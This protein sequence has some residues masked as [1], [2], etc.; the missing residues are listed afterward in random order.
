VTLAGAFVTARLNIWAQGFPKVQWIVMTALGIIYAGLIIWVLPS[1]ERRKVVPDIARWV[2]A[3]TGA[4]DR[5]ASY[6]LNRWSAAF[7][8][9]VD[10]HTAMLDG[11]DEA[12]AFFERAEP[13]YCVMLE[14]AYDE[15]VAQGLPLRVAYVR[16]GMW[17]TSGRVLWRRK[18]P[19]T[20]FV[21]VTTARDVVATAR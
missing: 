5:V 13:F 11:P 3:H 12:R 14:P 10:R 4:S 15:F 7:R 1:L 2:V 16:E 19:P 9:Y 8:F 20:R 21:I 18:I 17:A 6:G